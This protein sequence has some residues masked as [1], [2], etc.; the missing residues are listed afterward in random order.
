MPS[1]LLTKYPLPPSSEA[2]E[3]PR[4]YSDK[5]ERQI[6]DLAPLANTLATNPEVLKWLQDMKWL[7][8]GDSDPETRYAGNHPWLKREINGQEHTYSIPVI[9]GILYWENKRTGERQYSA[10]SVMKDNWQNGPE[11][12][13]VIELNLQD[14]TAKQIDVLG[15]VVDKANNANIVLKPTNYENT[16][17]S[18]RPKI[19]ET[20][21]YAMER[22][23]AK[24]DSE[25]HATEAKYH[26]GTV[27]TLQ[28]AD[29]ELLME[30]ITREVGARVEEMFPIWK[31]NE[32]AER[33][34]TADDAASI[35]GTAVTSQLARV[36]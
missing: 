29:I 1:E 12:W 11:A 9:A 8:M 25:Y 21:M 20:P 34:L 26:N 23:H 4:S 24:L 17:P 31:D 13:S 35:L 16:P 18:S 28:I 27:Q 2:L 36:A 14:G 30:A 5:E 3:S 19:G 10:I 6:T 15:V 33:R 32:G 22:I 7:T